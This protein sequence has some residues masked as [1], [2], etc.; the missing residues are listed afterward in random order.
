VESGVMISADA[1]SL[2]IAYSLPL[3]SIANRRPVRPER[4]HK[5][6]DSQHLSKPTRLLLA[7]SAAT[8][9]LQIMRP[10]LLSTL[11]RISGDHSTVQQRHA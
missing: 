1:D 3:P 7:P 5:S 8:K 9:H 4:L 11:R 10:Q 2:P 6:C